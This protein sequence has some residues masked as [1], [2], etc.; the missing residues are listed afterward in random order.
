MSSK[1]NI[2]QQVMTVLTSEEPDIVSP[3]QSGVVTRVLNRHW[4]S[5]LKELQRAHPWNFCKWRDW[6][7]TSADYTPPF[8]WKYA[9]AKPPSFLRIIN[10]TEDGKQ[11]SRSIPYEI[12]GQFILTD[13][14]TKIPVHY[15]RL[16][17]DPTKF[18]SLFIRALVYDLASK[19]S[20]S[21]TGKE[22]SV[23]S[24]LAIRREALNEARLI[25]SIEENVDEVE[26]DD[27]TDM[28]L[29][30]WPGTSSYE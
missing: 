21:V 10:I 4:L 8:G 5:T 27:L 14:P 3:N 30:I 20:A 25:D 7:T 6:L 26:R 28:R 9:Y 11:S 1:T 22:T 24:F 15:T 23:Q 17:E 13:W 19:F 18:D 16:I 12:E 29:G 2:Y